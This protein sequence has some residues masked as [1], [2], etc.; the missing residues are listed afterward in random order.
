LHTFY[1]FFAGGGMVRAALEPHWKCAFAND[2]D[3]KKVE[4][5]IE[6]WGNQEVVHQDVGKL[7]TSDLRG[8][9]TLVWASFPCQDLSLAGAGAGLAGTRSGTFWPFWKLVEGLSNEGRRP[10]A[11]VI[12]N[13][14]GTVTSHKGA[15]FK[16]LVEAFARLGYRAGA[17]VADASDFVPQSRKRFFIVGIDK[18]LNIPQSLYSPTP[19]SHWAP[20]SLRRAYDTLDTH[21]KD[22]WIWW[23]PPVPGKRNISLEAVI[24][25]APKDVPWHTNA[26]TER[27]ISMM[28]DTNRKKIR[29]AQS[30]EK[31]LVGTAYR[32]TRIDADGQKVQRIEVRF[33]G[34]AGCLRTPA[35]GSSRQIVID[36]E[37]QTVKSRL[38]S[39]RETA[40]LMG[41]PDNYKLPARY[42]DAYHLTGDGVAVP[43]VEHLIGSIIEPILA[44]AGESLKVA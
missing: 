24:E 39:A 15:D 6:N 43:V 22:N 10:A 40:R 11:V 30:Q 16:A 18:R 42:N 14:V 2:Y 4:A 27:L 20:N 8:K 35:G 34:L 19:H 1:E 25:D 3:A 12:E 23:S 31:R 13:V 17:V 36:I 32:R 28:S 29:N 5:Y 21:S 9:P 44:Y 33:D 7:N 38:I 26:E 41:L 37:A